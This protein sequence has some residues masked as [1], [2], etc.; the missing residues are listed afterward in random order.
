MSSTPSKSSFQRRR[1][2]L[3]A[4][5]RRRLRVETLEERRLLAVVA[6][7]GFESGNFAGGSEQWDTGSWVASGDATV[8]SDTSPA[9]GSKHA[10]LRRSTGDLQRTV[11]VTGLTD[12]RLQFSAK[13]ISFEG[14]D[15]ADVK[16]S[17]DGTNWTT[18]QSFVNGDDD[19]QYHDYDLAVPDQG[20]TLHVRFDAGMSGSG[21]YWFLDNVQVTGTQ[22][23]PPTVSISDAEA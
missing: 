16:V 12:V 20:N 9:S 23:G 13:L 21:D 14:S 3:R 19:G 5:A 17:G 1:E 15:R 11:D 22:A 7:D 4:K 6:A 10:R 8:R 2:I 18:L